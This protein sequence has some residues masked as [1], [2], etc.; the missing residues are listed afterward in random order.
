[1]LVRADPLAA[2]QTFRAVG[3]PPSSWLTPCWPVAESSRP[4][5]EPGSGAPAREGEPLRG[6]RPRRRRRYTVDVNVWP[7][8]DAE[9]N[10]ERG[11][12][13]HPSC[14]SAGQPPETLRAL[15]GTATRA[16]LRPR[17]APSGPQARRLSRA[18]AR[19]SHDPGSLPP[20]RHHLWLKD[21]LSGPAETVGACMSATILRYKRGHLPA[22]IRREVV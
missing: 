12:Y 17:A 2:P 4:L 1:M 10:P 18:A 14:H 11:F 19:F 3:M 6:L 7:R 20:A 8:C 9:T 22:V 13:Y 5:T 21:Q 16:P 15:A